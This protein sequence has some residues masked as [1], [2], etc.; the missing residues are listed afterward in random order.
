MKIAITGAAGNL[1]RKAAEIL[2]EHHELVLID[3]VEASEATVFDPTAPGLRRSEPLSPDWPYFRSDVGDIQQLVV[4]LRGAEV[5][6]HLAGWLTGH[7]S[8]ARSAMEVNVMGTFNIYEAAREIGARRVVNA[9]SIN[10][11][12]SI[13]WRVNGFSPSYSRLP[14]TESER[15]VPEDPYSLSK[16]ITED[17]GWAYRRAHSIEAVNLRFA[18]V[19]SDAQYDQALERGLPE[20]TEWQTDL[21]SWVHVRD[22]MRGA[23]LAATVHDP[24]SEPI[25]IGAADTTAPEPTLELVER[26]RPEFLHEL[27]EPILDRAPLLSVTRARTVLGYTPQW[28]LGDALK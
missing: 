16:G 22:W 13:Y 15:R 6:V 4:A 28:G 23:F 17:I 2:G 10:A 14:L 8:E 12:G 5:V 27:Q 9:S 18:A 3:R 25:V 7:W 24:G 26:F 20:S 21:W 1:G 19:W 11:F